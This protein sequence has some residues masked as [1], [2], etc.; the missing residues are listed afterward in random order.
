MRGWSPDFIP[1]LTE[2]ADRR[3]ELRHR[4]QSLPYRAFDEQRRAN[5]GDVVSNKRLG[6]VLSKI[7]AAYGRW[8]LV[9]TRGSRTSKPA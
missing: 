7:Q 3:I 1:K 9:I 4:D 8:G 6:D 5:Q 2:Y